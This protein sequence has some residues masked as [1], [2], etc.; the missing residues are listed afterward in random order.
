MNPNH[1]GKLHQITTN[2]KPELRSFWPEFPDPNPT[3]GVW[4]WAGRLLWFAQNHRYNI[5]HSIYGPNDCLVT[6]KVDFTSIQTNISS[7]NLN[8]SLPI[9]TNF[10]PPLGKKSY[11]APIYLAFLNGFVLPGF[12]FTP[13]SKSG[14]LLTY[15]WFSRAPLCTDSQAFNQV[16]LDL[17]IDFS[18]EVF[19]HRKKK[20][21][22]R[23]HRTFRAWRSTLTAG[24]LLSDQIRVGGY[25]VNEKFR[26]WMTFFA[27]ELL[28]PLS[29]IC[30]KISSWCWHIIV[31]RNTHVKL[32]DSPRWTAGFLKKNSTSGLIFALFRTNQHEPFRIPSTTMDHQPR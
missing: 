17:P 22:R 18:P 12:L 26:F 16:T 5:T 2:T 23:T 6:W 10:G 20:K 25:V 24:W 27:W 13:G 11:R 4:L 31:V 28:F 19:S 1:L 30:W 8:L 14:S 9:P 3:F 32:V 21:H 15:N 7:S 29:K